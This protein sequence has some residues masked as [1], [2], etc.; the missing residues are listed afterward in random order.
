MDKNKLKNI[1]KEYYSDNMVNSI[2]TGRRKPAYSCILILY[3][4]YKIPFTAWKDIKSFLDKSL[5]N[6]K[7]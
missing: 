3:E 1:L 5:P 6:E 2:I 7:Q 4:K